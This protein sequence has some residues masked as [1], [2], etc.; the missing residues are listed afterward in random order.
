MTQ[1]RKYSVTK[2][3]NYYCMNPHQTEKI[4]GGT[5]DGI[6]AVFFLELRDEIRM[7]SYPEN[8]KSGKFA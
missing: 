8:Q 7:F 2:A 6:T 4:F 1:L 5:Q 3:K